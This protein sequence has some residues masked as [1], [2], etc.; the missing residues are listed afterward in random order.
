MTLFSCF[1]PFVEGRNGGFSESAG[2]RP[3]EGGAVLKGGKGR[4]VCVCGGGNM[5]NG[6][7]VGGGGGGGGVWGRCTLKCGGEIGVK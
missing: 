1:A 2:N 7:R 4:C 6:S 3:G 5:K